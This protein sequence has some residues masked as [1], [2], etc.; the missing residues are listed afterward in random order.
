MKSEHRELRRG[1]RKGRNFGINVKALRGSRIATFAV[2][3]LPMLALALLAGKFVSMPLVQAYTLSA[4]G[5]GDYAATGDRAGILETGNYFESYLPRLTKGTALLKAGDAQA[6]QGELETSLELWGK[7]KDLNKPPHA[8]CKRRNNRALA[9]AT[10]A[11]GTQDPGA[12][13]EELSKA[14]EVLKPCLSGGSSEKNNEDKESTGN[15]GE[16]IEKKREE[17]EGESG[18][19]ESEG[20]ES[21]DPN[22]G[23]NKPGD[24]NTPGDDGKNGEEPS[25]GEKEEQRRQEELRKRNNGEEKNEGG[26][27]EETKPW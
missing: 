16:K 10:N 14:E 19:G 2:L 9:M 22:N 15:N 8:E 6:A 11:G 20:Q 25:P 18:K 17:A 4:Y 5:N 12:R 13:A 26:K 3:A 21:E 7:G 1:A 27:N 23:E 24:E